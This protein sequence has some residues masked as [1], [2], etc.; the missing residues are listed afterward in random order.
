[1]VLGNPKTGEARKKAVAEIVDRADQRAANVIP[2]IRAIQRAG[3]RITST[4][5]RPLSA[6]RRA[7][8]ARSRRATSV[9]NELT[10]AIAQK[11][12]LL[13]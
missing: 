7:D 11:W 4:N 10:L 9:R 5:C 13:R 6:T 2:I 1:M 12:P 3:S 8:R